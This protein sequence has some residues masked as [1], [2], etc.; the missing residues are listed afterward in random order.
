MSDRARSSGSRGVGLYRKDVAERKPDAV[1]SRRTARV[2]PVASV[3]T[4]S[5]NEAAFSRD[6]LDWVIALNCPAV[7]HIIVESGSTDET[8]AVLERYAD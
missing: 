6:A 3:V 8:P 5:L 7:E 2:Y 4:L 1:N